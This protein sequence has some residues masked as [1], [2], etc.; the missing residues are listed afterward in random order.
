MLRNLT[1]W[2]PA[3][4][5]VF[6]L[7]ALIGNAAQASDLRRAPTNAYYI[8]VPVIDASP[9]TSRRTVSH[10][11]QHC[12]SMPE[13]YSYRERRDHHSHHQRQSTGV[14]PGLLGGLIGGFV[15]NQFGGGSGRTALTV[16]GALAGS[17]IA[18]QASAPAGRHYY[19]RYDEYDEYDQP[20]RR[21]C[22][23]TWE[24]RVSE[25]VIGYDVTYEYAG[26]Q[27][28]KRVSRHPGDSIDV[29]VEVQE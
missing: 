29:R 7:S 16:V 10:P 19:D 22:E 8:A 9:V 6:T 14:M 27:F 3:F 17:S 13:R 5:T 15:G 18:R 4:I 11:V 21:Y 28:V 12:R 26:A 24:D 1:T 2:L 25:Q 23:T 20:T